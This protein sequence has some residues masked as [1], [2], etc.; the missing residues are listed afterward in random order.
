MTTVKP[1]ET[2]DPLFPFLTRIVNVQIH[3][4]NPFNFQGDVVAQHFGNVS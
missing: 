1:E 3:P 4:V 2:N